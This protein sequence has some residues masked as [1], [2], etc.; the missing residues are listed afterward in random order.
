MSDT[1]MPLD[2]VDL[3]ALLAKID[4]DLAQTEK[5]VAEQRKLTNEANKLFNE[6]NKFLMEELKL[7]ADRRWQ[8]YIT[9]GG[10]IAAILGAMAAIVSVVL[11][12][13]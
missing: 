9:G 2:G 4:R 8:P 11:H 5:F 1:P 10:V 6:A 12:A 13:R 3:K 7:A